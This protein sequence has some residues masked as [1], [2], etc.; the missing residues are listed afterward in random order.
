[1]RINHED[2]KTCEES[3]LIAKETTRRKRKGK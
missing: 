1:V 3:P 2:E